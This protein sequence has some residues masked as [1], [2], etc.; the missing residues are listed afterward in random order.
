MVLSLLSSLAWTL[1]EAAA[2]KES[3]M[4][5]ASLV[6]ERF[7]NWL[8]DLKE[9]PKSFAIF[10]VKTHAPLEPEYA[11]IVETAILKR[12][13]EETEIKVQTCFDCRSPRVTLNEDRIVISKGAPDLESLKALA[14]KQNVEAFLT[15]EL[16]RTQIAVV[17][18]AT[19]YLA[20]SGEVLEAN[21][22]KIPAI[23]FSQAA[24]QFMA[25]V[26]TGLVF[27]PSRSGTGSFPPLMLNLSLIEE[28]GI[29]KAGIALGVAAAPNGFLGYLS[30][31]LG[32]RQV[33]GASGLYTLL[34]FNLGF[35]VSD[36]SAGPY[37]RTAFDLFLGSF[38]FVGIDASGLVPVYAF[39]RSN[40][41]F[42]TA[43]L[44]LGFN[45][46]R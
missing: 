27:G 11:T 5:A 18:Q 28:I 35:G 20:S 3:E 39:N 1:A 43:A 14:K 15:I 33:W 37:L 10:S 29:G 23:D 45:L 34:Q 7:V 46:G 44:H 22:F 36:R 31:T 42:G 25:S 30:P 13:R 40:E 4:L 6:S 2:P 19:L 17:A 41:F 8:V 16:H 24:I 38:A 26:G 32:F 9:P 21:Q 12:M